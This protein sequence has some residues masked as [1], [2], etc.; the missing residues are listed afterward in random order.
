MG[1]DIKKPFNPISLCMEALQPTSV[2]SSFPPNFK[3]CQ[4]Y[5]IPLWKNVPKWKSKLINLYMRSGY[6][7]RLWYAVQLRYQNFLEWL[8][9]ILAGRWG[10]RE[11]TQI[12][13]GIPWKLWPWTQKNVPVCR[14]SYFAYCVGH[15]N[16][17]SVN[18]L[19]P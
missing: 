8:H 2:E 11:E 10:G 3:I 4:M 17:P 13:W 6:Y 7:K 14:Y 12:V 1:R 18:P 15:G 16:S 19:R 9:L 5:V